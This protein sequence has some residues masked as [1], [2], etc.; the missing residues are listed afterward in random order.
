MV[1]SPQYHKKLIEVA[2]PLEAINV[3][4]A[5]EKSIR[6]GHPSTIHL[7]WARRPLA[8]CR[9][10]LFASLVDDPS[11]WPD[12]F[13][14]DEKQ[15]EERER[16]F[17]IIEEM[18]IWDNS[19]NTEV[20]SN[21]HAEI[22]RSISRG[23]GDK[24]P[25][26]VEA[27]RKYIVENAPPVLDP[28]C[29][30]GSIPLEAQRLGLEAHGSDLNPVAVLITKALIEIPPKFCGKPPI[31]PESREQQTLEGKWE[32]AK[33]LAEDVRYYGRW[34]RDE[35]EKRIGYLYPKVMVTEELARGRQDLKPYVGKELKVIAWLWT[36]TV[37]SP[38]PAVK[39]AYVPLLQSY[40]L[41]T[42]K[43]KEAWIEPIVDRATNTYEFQVKVGESTSEIKKAIDAGTKI[44]RG[45]KFKCLISGEPISDAHVKAEGMSN[46][47]GS[48]LLAIVAEGTRGRVYLSPVSSHEIAISQITKP[49]N[50]FGID[51]PIAEEKRA[52]WCY[53]Y[54]LTTFDKLFTP[55]QLVALSI[56]SDLVSETRERV[57]ADALETKTLSNDSKNLNSGGCGKEAYADAVSVYLGLAVSKLADSQS[58]LCLW[59]PSMDQTIHVFGRQG[60]PMVWNYSE[61]NLF[62]GMAGDFQV[63]LNNM[64]RVLDGLPNAQQG[65]V[66]QLD[67]TV[68]I[69]GMSCPII[70]TDPPYYDNIG[71][72][73]ISDFFY[74][75]LRRSLNEIFPSLFATML[76]P[77]KQEL[78][79]SI[80]RHGGSHD[81]AMKFFEFGLGQAFARMHDVNHPNYPLTVYYAF[82]QAESE[83]GEDRTN[84]ADNLVISTGW[85]TML[86]GLIRSGFIIQGTWPM[87]TELGNRMVSAGTNALASSIVL[88]CRPRPTDAPLATRREFITALKQEL[89]PALK[90][91]QQ[92]S[93]A[94]VDLAQASIGPGMAVFTRYT[95]VMESDG[96]PMTVRTALA[97]I[98]QT[99]DEVLAEQEGE[100]DPDTR[101]A[102]AWF[103]QFGMNEGAYGT[104]ETLSKAKNTAINALVSDGLIV[105]KA[106]K[107]K[108]V[109]RN[110]MPEDWSPATDRRL[111]SWESTQNLI[112][113]LE[114]KGESGAAEL[115]K[116]LGS[117]MSETARDLAY[118]L[119][120]ICDRKKWTT[121][122]LSY[123]GLITSW[124]EIQ[125]LVHA[126]EN[127]KIGQQ[128]L[129]EKIEGDER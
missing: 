83:K 108:L 74:I 60:L 79:A 59:K 22:A 92:S 114:Q 62:S 125:T 64:M 93:I 98:N 106:G 119:Y 101:W 48:K 36:R 111:T 53:L 28:F 113:A 71:Y 49:D 75:W 112:R 118:R 97:L 89:P 4:S 109:A 72:S 96:S 66:R 29:G 26:G 81:E 23:K 34:M 16:I 69:N 13:P 80:Y 52:I 19:N 33:G 88:V 82:K 116:K 55:R 65:C 40:W 85:E 110:E 95:K 24:M 12:L 45:C 11:S 122:A 6:H 63:T 104:A 3:A 105:A 102:I 73:D 94:P 115:L 120:I 44:G 46:K 68:T 39:N 58:S 87:R 90:T 50:L 99:L 38:N 17:K 21:V 67:A 124:P 1:A 76:T 56:L 107:V 70:S 30:G 32:G 127:T 27:I 61:S 31:N 43:G 41:S 121:E 25:V 57:I 9:A 14:T 129:S 35:A 103:E 5:R 10:V 117:G 15:K 128:T 54:G 20:F 77:K 78:I 100:F 86:S 84:N 123:N 47:L 51:T 8:A 18:V 91:L 126:A 2:L 42:K 37:K 7:W